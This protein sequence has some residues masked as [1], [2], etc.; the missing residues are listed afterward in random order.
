VVINKL[1]VTFFDRELSSGQALVFLFAIVVDDVVLLL[2]ELA[3]IQTD[4]RGLEPRITG[5]VRVV[6]Q[7]RRLDEVF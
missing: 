1:N 6:D 7:L 4:L 5:L 3:E 2:D